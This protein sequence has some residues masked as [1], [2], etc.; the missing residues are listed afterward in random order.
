MRAS[1]TCWSGVS[2]LA[3]ATTLR[4][5]AGD[6]KTEGRPRPTRPLQRARSA[7][8]VPGRVTSIRGTA[9]PTPSA[10]PYSANGAN[11]ATRRSSG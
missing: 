1:A 8:R 2:R 6:A 4:S 3:V 7:V 9:A 5:A 11:A 10:G